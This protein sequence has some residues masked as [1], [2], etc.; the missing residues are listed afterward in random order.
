MEFYNL[1]FTYNIVSLLGVLH[2]VC[3]AS[4]RS[5]LAKGRGK[6]MLHL[7]LETRG[8]ICSHNQVCD[9]HTFKRHFIAPL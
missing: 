2:V 9:E 7:D 1:R 3:R 5:S 8:I 6:I 4:R